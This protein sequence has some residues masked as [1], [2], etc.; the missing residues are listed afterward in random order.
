MGRVPLLA[1]TGCLCLE[2]GSEVS[3]VSSWDFIL[4]CASNCLFQ[5]VFQGEV[6]REKHEELGKKYSDKNHGAWE[7]FGRK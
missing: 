7:A 6:C 5:G 2:V 1:G 4:R 3:I